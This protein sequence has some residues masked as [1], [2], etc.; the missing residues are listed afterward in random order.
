MPVQSPGHLL[1]D[2]EEPSGVAVFHQQLA[3][4]MMAIS[5]DLAAR[6]HDAGYWQ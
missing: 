2:Y 3:D 6:F 5:T 4:A 1:A